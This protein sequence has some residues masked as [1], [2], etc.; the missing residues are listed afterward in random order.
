MHLNSRRSFV[1][2]DSLFQD[3]DD[4]EDNLC[5]P[6]TGC[7]DCIGSAKAVKAGGSVTC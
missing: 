2:D 3:D 5:C 1:K 6:I 7:A 4:H